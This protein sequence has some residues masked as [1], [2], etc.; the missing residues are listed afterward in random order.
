MGYSSDL[1]EN[2]SATSVLQQNYTGMWSGIQR[3]S[4]SMTESW[5]QGPRLLHQNSLTWGTTWV[6]AWASA[7][8]AEELGQLL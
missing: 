3:D 4:E 6:T 2:F 7:L 5:E 8:T 1:A